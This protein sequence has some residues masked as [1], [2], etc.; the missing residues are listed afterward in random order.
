ML[1]KIT[2]ASSWRFTAVSALLFDMTSLLEGAGRCFILWRYILNVLMEK[3]RLLIVLIWVTNLHF[4]FLFGRC[5]LV[6]E[7]LRFNLIHLL[8]TLSVCCFS[9]GSLEDPQ[10]AKPYN[11]NSALPPI[12]WPQPRPPFLTSDPPADRWVMVTSG[13]LCGTGWGLPGCRGWSPPGPDGSHSRHT[14]GSPRASTCPA[15]AA[16]SGPGSSRCSRRSPSTSLWTGGTP[17]THLA[18]S[19]R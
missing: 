2:K 6:N 12:W 1:P 4:F 18:G 10:S 15:P 8:A 3:P 11:A 7:R 5:Q 16:W 14:S 17:E 9:L 13:S 19:I